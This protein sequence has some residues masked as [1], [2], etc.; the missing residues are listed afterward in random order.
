MKCKTNGLYS[1]GEKENLISKVLNLQDYK[2]SKNGFDNVDIATVQI[3][4]NDTKG[5]LCEKIADQLEVYCCLEPIS[6]TE[7]DGQKLTAQDID[8]LKRLIVKYPNIYVI[9]N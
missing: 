7:Y 9:T 6:E 4:V 1:I 2:L 8:V 5:L 3:D